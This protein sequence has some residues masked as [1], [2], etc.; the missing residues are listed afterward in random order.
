M[1]RSYITV[2]QEKE[3]GCGDFFE[4]DGTFDCARRPSPSDENKNKSMIW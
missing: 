3:E 1:C 2:S 4:I